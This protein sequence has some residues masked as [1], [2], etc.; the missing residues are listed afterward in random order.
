MPQEK[1][2]SYHPAHVPQPMR[3]CSHAGNMNFEEGTR[4]VSV[5]LL[6][7]LSSIMYPLKVGLGM[8]GISYLTLFPS[9]SGCWGVANVLG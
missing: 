3:R 6:A 2:I 4:L 7:M 5:S 9:V 1:Y 8:L